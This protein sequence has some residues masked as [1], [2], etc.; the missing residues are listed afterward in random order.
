MSY[1]MSFQ[2]ASA[3]VCD[4]KDKYYMDAYERAKAPVTGGV[5][6]KLS[7]GKSR[8]APIIKYVS[9][10]RLARNGRDDVRMRVI[11]PKAPKTKSARKRKGD[12]VRTFKSIDEANAYHGV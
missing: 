1:R 4:A 2:H 9:E 5:D 12:D 8:E 3:K 11:K 10:S 6:L 7:M